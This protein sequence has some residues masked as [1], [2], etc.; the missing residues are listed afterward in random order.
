MSAGQKGRL[1]NLILKNPDVLTV[2]LVLTHL[3]QYEIQLEDTP[4]RLVPYR[5][6]PPKMQYLRE[7]CN[8]LLNIRFPITRAP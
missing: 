6:A 8:K 3:L 5:L 7:Q 4:V 2:K 1:E